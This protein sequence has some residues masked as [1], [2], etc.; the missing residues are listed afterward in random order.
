LTTYNIKKELITSQG[1]KQQGLMLFALTT[2]GKCPWMIKASEDSMKKGA[3]T[4]RKYCDDHKCEKRLGPQG[5]RR[6]FSYS[7]FH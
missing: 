2:V 4:V 1:M 5:A 3:I 7:I 6:T